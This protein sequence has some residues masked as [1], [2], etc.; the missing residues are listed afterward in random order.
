MLCHSNSALAI[1]AFH[2]LMLISDSWWSMSVT[3][4]CQNERIKEESVAE[5]NEKHPKFKEGNFWPRNEQKLSG[6]RVQR[7]ALELAKHLQ[8]KRMFHN[9]SQTTNPK[10]SVIYQRKQIRVKSREG[11]DPHQARH[12]PAA[13]IGFIHLLQ[14]IHAHISSSFP[15]HMESHWES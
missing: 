2:S 14:M 15:Q 8:P 7:N 9:P 6:S 12:R 11:S 1:A 10:S 4:E 3:E 5:H 13:R